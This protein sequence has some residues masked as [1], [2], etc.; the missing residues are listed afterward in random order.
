MKSFTGQTVNL[1]E[2]EFEALIN[3]SEKRENYLNV[4]F[5]FDIIKTLTRRCNFK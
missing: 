1:W 4:F 2:K 5:I 3:K